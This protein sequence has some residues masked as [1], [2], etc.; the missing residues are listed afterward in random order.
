MTRMDKA[1]LWGAWTAMA[2]VALLSVRSVSQ[3]PKVEPWVLRV[4]NDLEK[5]YRGGLTGPV[6]KAPVVDRHFDKAIKTP[7]KALEWSAFIVPKMIV[8]PFLPPPPPMPFFLLPVASPRATADLTGVTVTWTVATAE[9][10]LPNRTYPMPSKPEGFLLIREDERGERSV[11]ADLQADAR[12]FTDITAKA[13]ASYRYWVAVKGKESDPEAVSVLKPALRELNLPADV[14]T[15]SACRVKLV[16]GDRT[17]AVLRVESYDRAQKKWASQLV[18]AGP[19]QA[20]GASGWTLKALK[21]DNFTL[22]A[23]VADD[24]GVA[25]VITTTN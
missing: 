20:I 14:R 11:I 17:T 25:R 22:V 24:D 1:I 8:G 10:D 13:H 12:S 15:P 5:I 21:F 6:P 16:G 2:V 7:E 3:Q 19:G 23:D 4:E 9:T 18:T